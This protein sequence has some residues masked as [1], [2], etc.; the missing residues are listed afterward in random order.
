M[1]TLMYATPLLNAKLTARDLLKFM[2][3]SDESWNEI[4]KERLRSDEEL[5]RNLNI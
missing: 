2:L 4:A 5:N 3:T 1:S